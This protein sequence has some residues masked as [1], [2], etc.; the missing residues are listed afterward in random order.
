MLNEVLIVSRVMPEDQPL[1]CLPPSIASL[2]L[3]Q[4]GCVSVVCVRGF[5]CKGSAADNQLASLSKSKQTQPRLSSVVEVPVPARRLCR[6]SRSACFCGCCSGEARWYGS[7][8]SAILRS[9]T[10]AQ[11]PGTWRR[12]ASRSCLRPPM[13]GSLSCRLVPTTRQCAHPASGVIMSLV[14]A[15]GLPDTRM[16]LKNRLCSFFAPYPASGVI[17]SSVQAVG[18]PDTPM[19]LK[20]RSRSFFAAYFV[21]VMSRVT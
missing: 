9:A 10:R 5:W 19:A 8:A 20:N 14:Q 16:A 7:R 1:L 4:P 12:S 21:Q 13:S 11:L 17:M 15:V 3:C 6:H 18:L 2:L